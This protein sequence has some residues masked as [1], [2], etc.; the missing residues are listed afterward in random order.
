[1]K[2]WLKRS[3][4]GLGLV[5]PLA[6]TLY[7]IFWLV[8]TIESFIGG[9]L[10]YFLPDLLYFPG[11][12]IL[13]SVG[14]LLFIGWTVNLYLFRIIIEYSESLLQR[15]PLVKT[16][17][18]GLKDLMTF[19]SKANSKKE[20]GSVVTVDVQGMKLIGFITDQKGG[21]TIGSDNP[22]EVAVYIPL[23]YQI[24]GFT[25]YVDH[26][27][28]KNL[29]IGVEEAMRIVVTANMTKRSNKGV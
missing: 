11:L 2:E 29:D 26:S 8:T 19:V 6:L 28:L 1:M 7:L 22:D 12:G 21:Q 15:I 13:A 24:G 17:I 5:L 18:T 10:R 16:A 9:I 25:V 3:F 14:V 4:K 20:F 27:R 23:S